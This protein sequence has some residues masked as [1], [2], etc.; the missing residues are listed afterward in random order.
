MQPSYP[1][2]E[3]C[4]MK[5]ARLL[6]LTAIAL[7]LLTGFHTAVFAESQTNDD[8]KVVPGTVFKGGRL[9]IGN[10]RFLAALLNAQ[11]EYNDNITWAA[12]GAADPIIDD[13]IFHAFP[14]LYL[15]QTFDQHGGW[16]LGYEGDIAVYQD[17]NANDWLK[18]LGRFDLQYQGPS[19]PIVQINNDYTLTD[20]PFGDVTQFGLGT[21]TERWFNDFRSRF[22]YQFGERFRL[23][24]FADYYKQ[25]YNQ[26]IAFTQ[27]WDDYAVGTG[28]EFAVASKTW[29]FLRYFYGG[30]N[31]TT[32]A[33]GVTDTNNADYTYHQGNIG[34]DWEPG[35]RVRGQVDF[36]YQ[37]RKYKNTTDPSGTAYKDKNTWVTAT[38]ISYLPADLKNVPD[39][40]LSD[41]Y[42]INFNLWRGLYSV[43]A[44]TADYF[45]E[46][47]IGGAVRYDLS[48]WLNLSWYLERSERKYQNAVNEKAG[49]GAWGLDLTFRIV[50]WL[51]LEASYAW[52]K[53]N[54]TV[55]TNDFKINRVTL[56]LIGST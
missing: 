33:A 44:N 15:D 29:L 30:Q 4:E 41:N 31:Y 56:T 11:I 1:A 35:S 40:E 5:N 42:I 50:S 52:E 20:D 2:K 8:L 43:G 22:G 16:R 12:G 28:V 46:A 9:H 21:P 10:L 26:Q 25:E 23:L 32:N 53:Q 51:G 19:K 6:I 7:F 24:G 27:N 49:W 39:Y 55:S 38:S 17:T 54:S 18:H 37:R 34:I 13:N 48:P 36:G 47:G 3:Q 14:T 45:T